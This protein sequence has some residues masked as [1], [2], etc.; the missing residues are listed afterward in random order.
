MLVVDRAT[1]D[2]VGLIGPARAQ[3]SHLPGLDGLRALAVI[4][5]L[6]FHAGFDRMVGGYLG[7]STFF[8]LSGFLITTLLLHEHRRSGGVDLRSFWSRRYRRLWPASLAL[9]AAVALLFTPLVATAAQRASMRG[10]LLAS[11][12]QVANWHYIFSGDSYGEL[13]LSPSP[14]LHFWSLAIEEQ[15]YLLFPL[16]IVGLWK[17]SRGRPGRLAAGLAVLT[18]CSVLEPFVFA[19]SDDRIYFGTDTRAAELLLG[20]LLAV[21]LASDRVRVQLVARRGWRIGL[22][23][24]G[25]AAFGL[26]VWWW[27]SL[28]QDT[29][30][31]YRGGFALYA[32]LSCVVITAVAMPSGPLAALCGTWALRWVGVRSYG[33]YLIHWPIYL[34]VWQTWP[35]LGR[36]WA[37]LLAVSVTFVLAAIS[38]RVLEGPVRRGVWPR[39]G[40]GVGVGVLASVAVLCA[41]LVPWPE[42]EGPTAIDFEEALAD[43]QRF[44]D[45]SAAAES[46]PEPTPDAPVGGDPVPTTVPPPPPL[47]TA[48]FGDSTALTAGMGFFTEAEPSGLA[49]YVP[50]QVE[51]GCGVSR[52]EASRSDL[53]LEPAAR[54]PDWRTVWAERVAPGGID[55]AL[56]MSSVW[57]LPD[58]VLP[59]GTEGAIGDP[60]VDDF[61]RSEFVD[62]VD[63]LSSTGALVVVVNTPA[64]SQ[65][66]DDGRNEY[67]VRQ[68][69]P[70]RT[71]RL[72]QILAEVV[73]AR[74]DRA[75]ILDLA[76]GM[77]DRIEDP[78][79]RP[80]G[81]HF[82][83]QAFAA[84]TVSWFGPEL[85][86]VHDSVRPT[87]AG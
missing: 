62:A 40:R 69:D 63:L 53:S 14:V 79:L 41:V 48:I 46:P 78:V 2:F 58:S 49:R 84:F 83:Q 80:D 29:W 18:A 32:L 54:C 8:T 39:A 30:W 25:L 11:L 61:I 9:L 28:P 59:D 77:A 17:W 38:F 56:L 70:A 44:G 21:V 13:F 3:I 19:M 27:W 73:A 4:A 22:P 51:L 57:E 50:G 64:F 1:K 7:V 36:V 55:V 10:D 71:A 5:V 76:G 60:A 37:T 20:G 24:A 33:I 82:D 74:P 23:L 34:T 81:V 65:W 68:Y 16:L 86:R 6:A 12:F 66:A 35:E 42:P 45:T 47:R 52:F 15:F 75:V 67:V 43:F 31:L 85:R 72:N 87:A 26:Q